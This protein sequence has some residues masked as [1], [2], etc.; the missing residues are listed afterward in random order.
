MHN[1]KKSPATEAQLATM[2][3]ERGEKL[4]MFLAARNMIFAKREK[5]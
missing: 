5:G 3:K 2:R 4:Q 1:V